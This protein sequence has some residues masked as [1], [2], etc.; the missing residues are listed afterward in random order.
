[1]P[2]VW[3]SLVIN[4]VVTVGLAVLLLVVGWAF[5]ELISDA[6]GQPVSW[7]D[8]AEQDGV[9]PIVLVIGLAIVV[10]LLVSWLLTLGALVLWRLMRGFRTIPPVVQALIAFVSMWI[11][12]SVLSFLAQIVFGVFGA[13]SGSGTSY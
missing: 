2:G 1:M 9:A 5:V 12:T 8:A 4:L 6:V 3:W 10:S 13:A 11:A 7:R